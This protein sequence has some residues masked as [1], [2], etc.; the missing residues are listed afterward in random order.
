[1]ASIPGLNSLNLED[2]NLTDPGLTAVLNSLSGNPKLE[3]LNIGSNKIDDEA[4]EALRNYIGNP[5][6]TL[7]S[8]HLKQ[9]DI[10]DGECAEFIEAL[11]NNRHLQELDMSSICWV[12]MRI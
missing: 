11:M 1:L 9:A 2:N 6:C 8:L 4:A 7:R 10:D 3:E 5:D 12:K